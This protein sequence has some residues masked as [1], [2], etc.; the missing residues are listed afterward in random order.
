MRLRVQGAAVEED[1]ALEHFAGVGGQ[2]DLD[3]LTGLDAVQV[4]L[5]DAAHRLAGLPH[6]LEAG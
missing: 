1:G 6:C 2:L 5:Q 4:F 3:A